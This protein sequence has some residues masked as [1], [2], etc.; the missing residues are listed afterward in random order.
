MIHSDFM[1]MNRILAGAVLAFSFL[2]YLFSM[3][4]TVPYWDSGEFIATAYILGVPHPP[5][6]PLYLIIGRLFSLIPFSADIAFRVNLISPVVSALAVMLLYLST[7][8]IITHYRGKVKHQMDAIIVFGGALVGSLAFAFTDSHWFNAV[9]AEVYSMSTFFTAI[10]VW[11]ILHWSERA[12]EKGNERYILI[13]AYMLGLATGVHLLI[14]LALPFIALIIYYRKFPFQWKTFLIT[15]TI[16]LAAYVLINHGI[17]NGF[18]KLVSSIKPIGVILLVLGIFGGMVVSIWYKKR[19]ASLILTSIVLILVGYSSYAMIFIRSGQNPNIDENN[20][21]TVQQAISYMEREQYGQMFQLPRRYENLPPKHKAVGSPRAGGYTPAQDRDYK[22]YRL[23]KQW[24]Y[25]LNYQVKKMY[26]RY[27][28]WQF[29]GRGPSGDAWVTDYGA[30]SREDGVAWFQFGLPLAFIMGMIGMVLHFKRDQNLAFSVMTLFLMLGMAIIFFVNQDNPQPRERDYSYVG[31]F[32]AFS[33]WIGIAG[34][35]LLEKL[36]DFLKNKST[37]RNIILTAVILQLILVPGV[38]LKANYHEHDR[39]G[40]RIAWDYSY[41]LLQSCEPNAILFTNGDN[42]TFPLWYLQEVE[43]IRTDVTVANLSLLNT[44]WY[45]KQMRDLRRGRINSK[46]REREQFI[47]LSDSQINEVAS[48]L[49]P[50][51]PKEN[52]KGLVSIPVKNDPLNPDG[53]IKWEIKPTYANAA[54]MVKDLMILRI[55]LDSQWEY[56][57]YFAVTVPVSNR[58]GLEPFLEMEGLVYR[59]KSHRID[60]RNPINTDKMWANLMTE[61]G[62]ETWNKQFSASEWK[63]LE[64][65]MWSKDY[66]PGYLF[67]NLGVEDIFYFPQTNIR[68]LQNIRSAYMQLAAHYYM[69]FRSLQQQKKGDNP[70][71]REAQRKALAVMDKMSDNIP[72]TT[73]PFD[74]KDLYYQVGRVYGELGEKARMKEIID[75]LMSRDD[76]SLRDKIDFGQVYVSELDSFEIG[77]EIFEKLYFSYLEI[78]RAVNGGQ[79]VDNKVWEEWRNRYSQIVSS[80]V[81]T[82]RQMNL[83]DEAEIVLSEW[84]GKN[85]KDP[86]AQKLLK[87]LMDSKNPPKN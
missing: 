34:S 71:A 68:L 74:S 5:G 86:V 70:E 22:F 8:K 51:P 20:P 84:L 63:D 72:E 38:M 25:F 15:V 36:Q 53:Y 57:V 55:I 40:N 78:E 14:L 46:S 4:D 58:L 30:N 43:G 69:E 45:I 31:S 9:E 64:E 79:L 11:L 48:G 87:D 17:I 10:V 16:T 59:V 65:E 13:I 85:P 29:A 2:V 19:L 6:S 28:L 83:N 7:V 77:K 62:S 39:S 76:L 32:F 82:Y 52:P 50:W 44:G 60:S 33:I 73:I 12:D 42:D 26:L 24:N 66:K 67:R 75:N 21:E 41:N 61:Y 54:I 80:L 3:A 18:P 27:F 1:R 81:F 37:A 35:A 56:P 49:M 23:D 47:N